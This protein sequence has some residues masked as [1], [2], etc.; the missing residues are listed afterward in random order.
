MTYDLK[1]ET[2][3]ADGLIKLTKSHDLKWKTR[4]AEGQLYNYTIK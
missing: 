3:C 2:R 4:C 1:G